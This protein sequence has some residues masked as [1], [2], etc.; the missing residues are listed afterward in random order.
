MKYLVLAPIGG[1]RRF[2]HDMGEVVSEIDL[3]IK[4]EKLIEDGFIK[5]ISDEEAEEI[6]AKQKAKAEEEGVPFEK[7]NP[8]AIPGDQ[9]AVNTELLSKEKKEKELNFEPDLTEAEK[10]EM[11]KLKEAELSA[12]KSKEE[13]LAAQ[14]AAKVEAEKAEMLKA[15]PADEVDSEDGIEGVS[16]SQIVAALTK[17]GVAFDKKASKTDLYEKFK[18]LS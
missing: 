9:F 11:L 18:M 5:E 3:V 15:E 2:P 17:A 10:A 12:L 7:I 6:I 14:E 1:T 8:S 4:A 13:E 16:K